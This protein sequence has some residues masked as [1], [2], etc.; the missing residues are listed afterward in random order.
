MS[1]IS[2]LWCS[3]AQQG[4]TLV[5]FALMS[6][7]LL[8][9]LGLIFDA[10]LDY[11][12]RRG[13]Q[14]AAD[15][16]ALR[17]AR[18]IAQTDGGSVNVYDEVV[19]AATSNGVLNANYVTC[20][21][22]DNDLND[23]GTCDTASIPGGATG[24]QVNVREEHTPIVMRALGVTTTG[25]AATAAA[26]VQIVRNMNSLDVP[27]LLCGINTAT[28][29]GGV[30][31]IYPTSIE[32][33]PGQG[34]SPSPSFYKQIDGPPYEIVNGAYSYDWNT[35]HG[36]G[37]FVDL[38][39]PTFIVYGDNIEKCGADWKGLTLRDPTTENSF[40]GVFGDDFAVPFD[41]A[42]ENSNR[43]IS[44]V[45]D[46]SPNRSINGPQGCKADKFPNGCIMLVPIVYN[47]P[48]CP[49]QCAYKTLEESKIDTDS[50]LARYWG[51]LYITYD[52]GSN[53]YR[54]RMIKNYPMHTDGEAVWTP[55]YVGPLNIALVQ[56]QN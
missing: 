47:N 37:S 15:L 23:L 52:S 3:Q 14:N 53:E 1:R 30:F 24:V 35:R 29:G 17:G 9:G 6:V 19:S 21:F 50:L 36:D 46:A 38:G 18:V 34:P 7:L 28:A 39:G 32:E 44:G 54:G 40:A 2:R 12:Y 25:T 55:S 42:K 13:M 8:A 16:A 26:Q 51:V 31:D 56:P 33:D 41:I 11:S 5:L 48:W 20:I 10:G 43:D 4:Q 22:L 45:D 27:F 49:T